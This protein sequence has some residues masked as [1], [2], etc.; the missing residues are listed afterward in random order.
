MIKQTPEEQILPS[1]LVDI[2]PFEQW[3]RDNA[4]LLGDACCAVLPTM[5]IG[6]SLGIENAFILAQSLASNF[7]NIPQAFERYQHRAQQRSHDLQNITHR[8]SKLTYTE[9]FDPAEVAQ[10]YQQFTE[11]NSHS[12]F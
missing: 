1:S 9:A 2:A 12:P 10:L 6:F 4:V 5:G 7:F 8:L 11:V 3:S